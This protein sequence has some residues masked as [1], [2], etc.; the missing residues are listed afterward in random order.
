MAHQHL[1]VK[2]KGRFLVI[3]CCIA[4]LI[5]CGGGG[6]NSG[7]VAQVQNT[8]GVTNNTNNNTSGAGN[9]DNNP[10]GPIAPGA[11]INNDL[12]RSFAIA[13]G[14]IA[15]QQANGVWNFDDE[16]RITTPSDAYYGQAGVL[17]FLAKL[18]QRQADAE[19]KK[20][21]L[22]GAA[23]LKEE[24][25]ESLGSGLFTG[26]S[27]IAYTYL[28]LYK[29]LQEPMW[30]E[31]AITIG[32]RLE[33]DQTQLNSAP[34]DMISGHVSSGLFFLKL[35]SVTQDV[36]WLNAAKNKA[37][38]SLTKAVNSG[39]GIKF[40]SQFGNN[41]V[42]YV[43]FAHGAAGAGY[44]Y[45][46]LSQ[47][48]GFSGEPYKKAA[49]D[50]GRW[51]R[52]IATRSEGGLNWYRR[53]PDQL[54]EQQNQWCHG[55][56][57]IGLFFAKLYEVTQDQ[58]DLSLAKEAA[59]SMLRIGHANTSLCHGT[60]GHVQLLLKLYGLTN[61]DSYLRSARQIGDNLWTSW[62]KSF[63]YP[64]WMGED[65]SKKIHNASLMTGNAGRGYAYLQ[66]VDP[67]NAAMPFLE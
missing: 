3:G 16:G 25:I 14:I 56:P 54:N 58:E 17:L 2:R 62:D 24:K 46:K 55:A 50:V 51:L 59:A 53:E 41:K 8:T 20:S 31:T 30:L 9:A 38:E 47:A 35:Y 22:K 37:N 11:P 19:I 52:S 34:G 43:G 60:S 39:A 23:W 49:Q 29:T 65:G 42:A 7:S 36:R 4:F 15:R 66:M 63:F 26:Q 10:I 28:E 12:D 44:F 61:D 21:I 6:A 32:K 67:K 18:Y 45:A 57:G 13:A 5:A 33:N 64:S 40:E 27:G 48:M 1:F